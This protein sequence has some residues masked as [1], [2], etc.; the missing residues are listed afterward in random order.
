M[1]LKR[2]WRCLHVYQSSFR[3]DNAMRYAIVGAG[4]AGLACAEALSRSGEDVMLF[5][6][7]RGP[8]GRMSTR[9]AETPFGAVSFDHGA[10]YF[11]AR[12]HEF[13][14]RVARWQ[15]EGIVAPW[16]AAGNDAWVGIPAM[17]APIR[18]M[19]SRHAVRWDA[20]V[21]KIDRSNDKWHLSGARLTTESFDGVVIALPAEQAETLLVPWEPDFAACA[22]QT[23]AAPCWTVMA[24]FD[25][26]LPTKSA[27]IADDSVIGWAALNSDKPGRAELTTWVIQADPRWS[28]MH[29]DDEACDVIA[30][31]L[32]RLAHCLM[33]EVP[34]PTY[35][36]AHRWRYARSGNAAR[37][38]L[39]NENLQLGV[40]GDWLL[41]PRVECA[42]LSGTQLA[43]KMIAG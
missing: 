16:P 9:R 15:N 40:G 10:Q 32:K 4:M 35:V 11:T 20:L 22:H 2:G 19:A 3:N 27:V 42:W 6:K 21:S 29:I 17:N 28:V 41:G 12:T 7:A 24:A 37:G 36:T 38:F 14:D 13:G 31:L 26:P 1:L 43:Q 18:D 8:G 30:V 34:E 33:V 23:K 5:D 25:T 39:F